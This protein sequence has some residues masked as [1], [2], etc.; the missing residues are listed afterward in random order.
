MEKTWIKIVEERIRRNCESALTK[1]TIKSYK[2]H[3]AVSKLKPNGLIEKNH[4]N[5]SSDLA[6][7]I[8][9]VH[10]YGQTISALKKEESLSGVKNIEYNYVPLTMVLVEH[11]KNNKSVQSDIKVEEIKTEETEK[12]VKKWPGI[13]EIM[14]SYQAFSKG[15][16]RD[17]LLLLFSL[18][19]LEREGE[20]ETLSKRCTTLKE[21]VVTKQS[22]VKYLERRHRE[23]HSILFLREQETKRLQ[24]LIDQ[25]NKIV[26]AFR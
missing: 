25:L 19:F 11:P 20:I 18:L 16:C 15:I 13:A 14:E 7:K 26:N 17:L 24:K 1:Y 5:N 8:P 6:F 12:S 9:I 4:N 2:K 10:Q 23:L 22:E 3:K 21:E